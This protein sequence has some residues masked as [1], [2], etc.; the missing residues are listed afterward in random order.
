[1]RQILYISS[2]SPNATIS[3][4]AILAQSCRNNQAADV[5]GLLYTDDRR[6]LQ[7]LEGEADAVAATFARIKADPRHQAVVILS[8]RTI[9]AREFG[10]WSM[11]HRQPSDAP[12][13]FDDRLERLLEGASDSLRGT[14]T[15][16]VAAR[17]AA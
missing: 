15:G 10:T 8:D 5:T 17:R 16:L 7:V 3:V 6:F 12:D 4:H 2:K 14:F 1:M 13:L 9:A 11:A